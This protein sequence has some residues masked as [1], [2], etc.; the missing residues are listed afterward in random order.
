MLY[1]QTTGLVCQLR[2][3]YRASRSVAVLIGSSRLIGSLESI[4]YKK[5][6]VG[7]GQYSQYRYR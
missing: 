1:I 5:S 3:C 7:G 2:C 6:K 4:G